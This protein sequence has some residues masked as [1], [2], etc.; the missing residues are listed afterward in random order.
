MMPL[1]EGWLKEPVAFQQ[2]VILKAL[3]EREVSAAPSIWGFKDPRTAT[4]L[5]LWIRIFNQTKIVPRFV[6]AIRKP[7][8]VIQSFIQQYDNDQAS[9]ELIFLLRTLDALYYTGGDCYVLSYEDWFTNPEEALQKL[10]EFVFGRYSDTAT[11]SLPVI[12]QLN[13]T[14]STQLQIHNPLVISLYD[15]LI[16]CK[17]GEINRITLMQQVQQQRDLVQ[18]FAPWCRFANKQKSQ[19]EKQYAQLQEIEKKLVN[20]EKYKAEN[21]QLKLQLDQTEKAMHEFYRAAKS[22]ER[23]L[24]G[25]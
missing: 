7:E 17:K 9:A 20:A 3:V 6:L 15:A 16:A 23:L 10:S 25:E 14:G 21:Q 8:A 18:S 4:F 2:Q 13:R 11:S 22:Y 1:H 24:S 19:R 5:P 12:D